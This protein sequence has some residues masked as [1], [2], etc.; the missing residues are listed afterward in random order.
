MLII[1]FYTM[2]KQPLIIM[3]D[4]RFRGTATLV[5]GWT[6]VFIVFMTEDYSR[7]GSMID[8]GAAHPPEAIIMFLR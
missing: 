5:I 2:V 6:C 7:D 4:R 3:N 1:I 8:H